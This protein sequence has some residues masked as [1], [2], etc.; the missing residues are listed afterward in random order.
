MRQDWAHLRHLEDPNHLCCLHL[1]S[2]VEVGEG[3]FMRNQTWVFC[4]SYLACGCRFDISLCVICQYIQC[5][6]PCGCNLSCC[7]IFRWSVRYSRVASL[8]SAFLPVGIDGIHRLLMLHIRC[9]YWKTLAMCY[10]VLKHFINSGSYVIVNDA[11]VIWY[12][13]VLCVLANLS[14]D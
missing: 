6:D 10:S 13:Y 7:R 9:Y 1:A 4:L 5:I 11:L 14:R 12:S 3:S 2:V 8:H